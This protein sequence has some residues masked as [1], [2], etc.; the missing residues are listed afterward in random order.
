MNN[1]YRVLVVEDEPR[2][3]RDIVRKIEE[4]SSAFQVVGEASSG[5]EGI[6]QIRRLKPELIITDIVM[7][8]IDGLEMLRSIPKEQEIRVIL[9]QYE[10]FEFAREAIKAGVDD[11]LLKPLREGDMQNLFDRILP[12]L[13]EARRWKELKVYEELLRGSSQPNSM[14]TNSSNES[15]NQN[16]S[17]TMMDNEFPQ[18]LWVGALVLGGWAL[19][20]EHCPKGSSSQLSALTLQWEEHPFSTE[21]R[22]LPA[23]RP[24][25]R[26]LIAP[27]P[28]DL[29]P[30]RFAEK[31][32]SL[33]S[34]DA[35]LSVA[36]TTQPT[37]PEELRKASR[38]LRSVLESHLPLGDQGFFTSE[39]PSPP[40]PSSLGEDTIHRITA[41]LREGRLSAAQEEVRQALHPW[42]T[43]TQ[44]RF[45]ETVSKLVRALKR[46]FAGLDEFVIQNFHE[47]FAEMLVTS[48]SA[49]RAIESTIEM[50]CETLFAQVA[51][52][53]KDNLISIMKKYLQENMAGQI[54]MKSLSDYLG[55]HPNYLTKRFKESEGT[56]PMAHLTA[57]RIDEA[58]RLL[59][60]SP[61]LTAREIAGMTGYED[62]RYFFRIFKKETGLTP[63]QFREL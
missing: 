27:W 5:G 47:R 6:R 60:E 15:T 24:N 50:L 35:P 46:N 55:Y 58:K 53:A 45:H 19:R 16:F 18:K 22:V 23:G 39:M 42:K 17:T 11:Y 44:I 20:P 63:S 41:L 56:T 28:K 57:L 38:T 32:L 25:L 29:S 37:S 62:S 2:I 31:L 13:K 8:Q 48:P 49:T 43:G 61:T 10:D 9:T 14:Q 36:H 40:L 21:L 51:P 52:P 7:P 54:T 12:K 4:C 30:N 34:H 1:P 33:L 59:K 26:F 3:R